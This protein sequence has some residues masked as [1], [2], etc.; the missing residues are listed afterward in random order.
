MG[1]ESTSSAVERSTKE[2]SRGA[3]RTAMA[4]T[5]TIRVLP[6]TKES[7]ATIRRT[8]WGS[9]AVVRSTTTANGETARKRAREAYSTKLRGIPMKVNSSMTASTEK[10]RSPIR[11]VVRTRVAFSTTYHTA[12]ALFSMPIR[13]STRATLRK[14]VRK[15]KE[16]T[17]SARELS[18]RALGGQIPS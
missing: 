12:K 17:T 16:P 14:G 7:G 9:S 8:G 18:L 4:Y 10:E 15:A 11:T 2:L 13:I 5:T 3:S 1:K 6:I